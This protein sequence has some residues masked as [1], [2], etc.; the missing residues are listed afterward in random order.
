MIIT[1]QMAEHCLSYDIILC[2]FTKH[3]NQT[4]FLNLLSTC[5][6]IHKNYHVFLE[7]YEFDHKKIKNN[8]LEKI[9]HLNNCN[10]NDFELFPN[11]FSLT[12]YGYNKS[13]KFDH[14]PKSLIM[15]QL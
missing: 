7:N 12:I 4:D 1:N 5:K 14:L 15:P 3:L 10:N 8:H 2:Q 13:L 11:L 6:N 9:R